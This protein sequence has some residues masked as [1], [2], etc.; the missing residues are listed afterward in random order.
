MYTR[1]S[2]SIRLFLLALALM[3][4]T[5]Q[6]PPPPAYRNPN[7]SVDERVADLL[8]RMTLEEKIAQLVCIWPRG[9]DLK[10]EELKHGLGQ[11]ARQQERKGPREGAAYANA[12]QKYLVE[13]TRLGIPA[14]FHECM[15]LKL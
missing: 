5:L 15:M 4:F 11:V 6:S 2:F 10:P 3:S 7:L 12:T 8:K 9:R 1:F 13:N 14:I